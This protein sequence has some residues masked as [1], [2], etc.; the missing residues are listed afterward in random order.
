MA[1]YPRKRQYKKRRYGRKASKK[2]KSSKKVATRGYVKRLVSSK[3]EDKYYTSFS[4]VQTVKTQ[5]NTA[6]TVGEGLFSLIPTVAL[7]NSSGARIGNKITVKR[8]KL[9]MILTLQP[10]NAITNPY[11]TGVWV[12]I[13]IFR[14]R[15][16]NS[17]SPTTGDWQ[18]FFNGNGANIPFQGSLLDME[19]RNNTEIFDILT[20]KTMFLSSSSNS[21]SIPNAT[22]TIFG[23]GS[24]SKKC[25]F[26]LGKYLTTLTYN[27]TT[28]SVASNK[29]LW[30]VIQPVSPYNPTTPSG[31]VI[32][33]ITITYVQ[34][35]YF[36]DA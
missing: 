16:S 26:Q 15:S 21:N 23:T 33:P 25:T 29:N 13:W 5:V 7:G 27:D 19:F 17:S 36:E 34:S 35:T 4:S 30:C 1:Y 3:I 11:G 9:D 24:P 10:Y 2:A 12:K 31:N 6:P 8:S 22:S 32:V 28:S 20:S 18:S 14:Y